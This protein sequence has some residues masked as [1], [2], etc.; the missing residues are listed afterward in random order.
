MYELEFYTE[1]YKQ[2]GS[3]CSCGSVCCPACCSGEQ[4]YE[5]MSG[6]FG[7]SLPMDI[8]E[9]I[10][11]DFN[12]YVDVDGYTRHVQ[13]LSVSMTSLATRVTCNSSV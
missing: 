10:A 8:I 4:L 1:K 11:A 9:D 12:I 7:L 13:Q 5:I 3:C 6:R 2:V